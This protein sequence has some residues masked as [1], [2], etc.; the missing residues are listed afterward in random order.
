MS[1]NVKVAVRIRPLTANELLADAKECVQ[2]V[3]SQP[4]VIVNASNILSYSSQQRQFTF[5]Y[6]F[7]TLSEQIHLYQDAICPL[8][9]N[10]QEGYNATIIAYGQTGSGKTFSMGTGLEVDVSEENQGVVPRVIK[11]LFSSMKFRSQLNP[12]GYEYSI[13]VSFLELYNE[14]LVDL[15]NPRPRTAEGANSWGGLAIREDGQGNILWTGVREEEVSGPDALLNCL[16]KGTLCRTTGSTDMN[17]SSSRSHAI[18]SIILKQ[19]IWTTSEI[20]TSLVT[21]EFL[22]KNVNP[23]T[24]SEGSWSSFSSKFHFVD[25]AGSERLKKTNAAGDRKKE[26]ISINQ[27]LLSLG[28]VISALGDEN[29][30]SS[31]IPFRDSKLT[32]LLQDSLG[33]NSQTLMLACISPR[34][35]N[36]ISLLRLN[37][38][39]DPTV[40][41]ESVKNKD[42]STLRSQND[43]ESKKI[44]QEL[45]DNKS[46]VVHY[47]EN[48]EKNVYEENNGENLIWLKRQLQQQLQIQ[49]ELEF[50]IDKFKK[51]VKNKDFEIEKRNFYQNRIYE[52]SVELNLELHQIMVERDNLL[53]ETAKSHHTV[54]KNESTGE[55]KNFPETVESSRPITSVT[56]KED[57][58][59]Q[60]IPNETFLKKIN[61]N[62]GVDSIIPVQLENGIIPTGFEEEATDIANAN[63][64]KKNVNTSKVIDVKSY[65]NQISDLRFRLS[66]SEDKL[67]WYKNVFE[68]L[69]HQQQHKR[70][71]TSTKMK[72]KLNKSNSNVNF[73]I[74]LL[75]NIGL[76]LKNYNTLNKNIVNIKNEFKDLNDFSHEKKLLTA[77]RSD[78]ELKKLLDAKTIEGEDYDMRASHYH[79]LKRSISSDSDSLRCVTATLKNSN[80]KNHARATSTSMYLLVNKI[81]ND[82]AEHEEIV[83]KL[84]RSESEYDAMKKAFEQKLEGLKVQL[85]Q[86]QRERDLALRRIRGENFTPKE[87]AGT[88]AVKARF[89]KKHKQLEAEIFDLKNKL[90]MRT[91][92]KSQSENLTKN[93]LA[94]IQ[95]LKAEKASMT[96]KLKLEA[97]RSR[98]LALAKEKEIEKLRLKERKSEETLRKLERNGQLQRLFVSKKSKE[99]FTASKNKIKNVMDILKRSTNSS[100]RISKPT[101]SKHTRHSSEKGTD[102]SFSTSSLSLTSNFDTSPPSSAPPVEIRAHFKKQMLEKELDGCIRTKRIQFILEE[103]KEKKTRLLNEQKELLAERERCISF[104]I[105]KGEVVDPGKQYYMDERLLIIDYESAMLTSRMIELESEK[106]QNKGNLIQGSDV[107]EINSFT[108]SNE[109]A[110]WENAMNILKSLDINEVQLVSSAYMQEA[111]KFRV[112]SIDKDLKISEKEK[113]V[114]ELRA[115]L[116]NMRAAALKTSMQYEKKILELHENA[117]IAIRNQ[118]ESAE[119]FKDS[120]IKVERS[121]P[122][123]SQNTFKSQKSLSISLPPTIKYNPSVLSPNPISPLKIWEKHGNDAAV[124]AAAVINDA[125]TNSSKTLSSLDDR[126]NYENLKTFE[127][128]FHSVDQ[129]RMMGLKTDPRASFDFSKIYSP[130]TEENL[131]NY[132]NSYERPSRPQSAPI[133]MNTSGNFFCKPFPDIKNA[134]Q[135]PH[136]SE[137]NQ[138]M[139]GCINNNNNSLNLNP[140]SE[141]KLTILK[142]RRSRS[143]EKIHKSSIRNLSPIRRSISQSVPFR[144]N[145]TDDTQNLKKLHNINTL[146]PTAAVNPSLD[147]NHQIWQE[148]LNEVQRQECNGDV[149]TI[150][151]NNN[152]FER[153]SSKH[154]KSSKAKVR[155]SATLFTTNDDG[156]EYFSNFDPIFNTSSFTLDADLNS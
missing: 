19:K 84:Q 109:D 110:S 97:E 10:F 67:C 43:T 71:T 13:S 90:S 53:I 115:A 152:V 130:K 56:E 69:S 124:V 156:T 119:K 34:L 11:Q 47:S 131:I 126:N 150:P 52:R 51:L 132:F 2:S 50:E 111:V 138:T 48:I 16:Q 63:T 105:G 66:E 58:E 81:Q 93:L 92:S 62:A 94:T 29:R 108:P 22:G 120:S 35:Q 31:Y 44:S 57:M 141:E 80:R 85:V 24:H 20:N 101:V 64:E 49:Q 118:I 23:Q 91:T 60:N 9:E 3:P 21:N 26:G 121:S 27:G 147:Y 117:K 86:V 72:Q 37:Q 1:T 100:N 102:F 136:V 98:D 123:R 73:E 65:V 7:N 122:I 125:L 70:P 146:Q 42:E 75:E 6:V 30:K 139:Q 78:P 95:S 25:L 88:L 96:K 144:E 55:E 155:N 82:I 4:I 54:Y 134:Y 38:K 17:A 128:L 77:L 41:R 61:L 87:K 33:G 39:N 5:D 113:V 99:D 59:S 135:P 154:T 28:N 76:K 83:S 36:E 112:E 79:P 142:A 40:S 148:A 114:L 133:L 151:N 104:E 116:E 137:S 46:E 145:Q 45:L 106:N 107:E 32:R 68:S 15:L 149:A 14:D 153:L 127:E 12:N 74:E 129:T 143:P 89:D 103:L 18:F 140:N 8:L